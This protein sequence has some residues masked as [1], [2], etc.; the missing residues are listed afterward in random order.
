M[1]IR[2]VLALTA[3][4]TVAPYTMAASEYDGDLSSLNP[5]QDSALNQK[6]P[7]T[8]FMCMAEKVYGSSSQKC[9]PAVSYFSSINKFGHHGFDAGKTLSKRRDKLNECS[10][11]DSATLSKI[12]AKFGRMRSF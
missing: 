8:V 6:D 4:L 12:L 11:A 7:C 1:N 9:R 5:V 2:M 10:S 3:T